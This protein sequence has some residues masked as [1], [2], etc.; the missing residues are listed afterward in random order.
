[1]RRSLYERA[2]RKP[3]IDAVVSFKHKGKN[4][5]VKVKRTEFT[6]GKTMT[7]H[8]QPVDGGPTFKTDGVPKDYE[9]IDDVPRGSR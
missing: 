9:V 6:D 7:Y 8:W 3:T 4:V 2:K 1:M 5:T